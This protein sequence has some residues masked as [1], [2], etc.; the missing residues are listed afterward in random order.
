MTRSINLYKIY[1][2]DIDRF[3]QNACSKTGTHI[4]YTPFVISLLDDFFSKFDHNFV[5]VDNFVFYTE[6]AIVA[7]IWMI[8]KYIEDDHMHLYDLSKL[9][10]RRIKDKSII[11]AEADIFSVCKN[12]KQYIPY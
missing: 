11:S 6:V 1:K 7:A 2:N 5:I 4:D 9:T 3:V 12:M 8:D 10:I